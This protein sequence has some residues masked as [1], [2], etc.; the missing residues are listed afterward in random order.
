VRLAFFGTA[1]RLCDLV[2]RALRWSGLES[3]RE[4]FDRRA[5]IDVTPSRLTGQEVVPS[6]VP[7]S[8][9]FLLR[10]AGGEAIRLRRLEATEAAERLMPMLVHDCTPLLEQYRVFRAAFPARCNPLLDGLG[11]LHRGVLLRVLAGKEILLVEQPP[12]ASLAAL[13]EAMRGGVG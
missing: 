10:R 7:F 11:E 6:D 12:Q 2:P 8:R 3:T 1:A 13:Y 9:L 5:W 4:R